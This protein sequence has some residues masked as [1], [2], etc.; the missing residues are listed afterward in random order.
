MVNTNEVPLM[1]QAQIKGRGQIQYAQEPQQSER[2][3]NEWSEAVNVNRPRFGDHV[4]TREYQ[5]SWRFVSNSGQDDDIIRPVIGAN[6]FPY[7]PGA[8]MKGAFL[9]SCTKEQA[10]RY[11]GAQ[12][13][14]DTQPGILRFHGAYPSDRNWSQAPLIDIVHP[15]QEWQVRHNG[16]HSAFLQVSLHQPMLVF[17]ISSAIQLDDDE[18][19]TIWSIWERAIGKGIGSRVSAGYGQTINHPE[20]QLISVELKG[21]GLAS[22]LIDIDGTP[23]FRP[24]MFKAALRG[25]TLRLFSAVTDERTAEELTKELWGGFAGARGAIVGDLGIA[26]HAQE[27]EMGRF[28]YNRVAM[29]IYDL[30]RGTLNILAMKNHST[31]YRNKLKS[32][33]TKILRFTLL[34]GGFGKSW[35]RVDHRIFFPEYLE[36]ENKPMIGCHWEFTEQSSK[37]YFPVNKI[38]HVRDIIDNVHQSVRDWLTFRGKKIT[39]QKGP[40]IESF[41]RQN[42]QIWGR[43]ADDEDDSLAV[44]WFHGPYLENN[45]QSQSIKGSSLTGR[46]GNIGRIYHRMYPHYKKTKEG[47]IRRVGSEYV[48]LLTIF[49]DGNDRTRQFLDFLATPNSEFTKLWGG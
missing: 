48:E 36:R 11:C 6:G 27:L 25:H 13:A 41:H 29:P 8:S 4:Q 37:Y 40:W 9:R 47:S 7:Y 14:N 46:M 45:T 30:K 31:E 38:E 12:K 3:V 33:A 35:R 15:Q 28:R 21:T 44:G 16:N 26:F 34:I 10:M 39:D 32:L 19:A 23:E 17:G 5:I 24:N 18:W 2:W 22:K 20:T 1:F 42:V 49:P 43:L